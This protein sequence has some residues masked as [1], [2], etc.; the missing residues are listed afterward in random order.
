MEAKMSKTGSNYIN[1]RSFISLYIVFSGIIML[2]SGVIL[3]LAPAGRVAKWSH[4]AILG[5]EKEEWQVLHTIFTLFFII[6]SSFHLYFNW[7]P[8]V[9]YLH[10]KTKEKISLKKELLLSLIVTLVI[11]FMA[12]WNLPPFNYV[13]DY[14][15]YLTESWADDS[16]EPPVPHAEAMTFTE[17]SAAIDM[18]VED[19]LKNLRKNGIKASENEVIKDVADRNSITPLELFKK[20]KT[21]NPA[22]A[23]TKYYGSG[24]G[25]KSLAE[26][27][28]QLDIDLADALKKLKEAGIAANGE[29][30]LKDIA[31]DN[32]K[33]PG[34]IMD[35]INMKQ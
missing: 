20:M 17:L 30:I 3:Y 2:V 28:K 19:M 5:L 27:C 29:T 23:E 10:K 18:N 1:W 24:L 33:N 12:L 11:F 13:M 15:E 14:G 26:V 6:A 9:S 21:V 34:D 25:R 31:R 7:K 22:N 16:N 8:F 32:G 4:I 35:I